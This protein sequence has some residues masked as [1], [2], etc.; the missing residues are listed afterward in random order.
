MQGIR[1]ASATDV[2]IVVRDGEG[3]AARLPDSVWRAVPGRRACVCRVGLRLLHVGASSGSR[4]Y[5]Q[6]AH[7]WMGKWTT[8][9]AGT[10]GISKPTRK[11]VAA[12]LSV[13]VLNC[14]GSR[15]TAGERSGELRI[16]GN[17]R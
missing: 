17:R 6:Q 11:H 10:G 5:D 14:V 1:V 9:V 15:S 16:Y 8:A 7:G 13:V 2:R 3:F 12:E 4:N